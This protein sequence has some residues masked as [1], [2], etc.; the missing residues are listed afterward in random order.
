MRESPTVTSDSGHPVM[1]TRCDRCQTWTVIHKLTPRRIVVA[2]RTVA[3]DRR[4][5][6]PTGWRVG[7]SK[8]TPISYDQTQS[9]MVCPRCATQLDTE[10]LAEREEEAKEQVARSLSRYR[11]FQDTVPPVPPSHDTLCRHH[12]PRTSCTICD[13]LPDPKEVWCRDCDAILT[14]TPDGGFTDSLGTMYCE[15]EKRYHRPTR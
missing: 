5:K 14:I 2:K 9:M 10:I 12:L 13:S 1:E 8:P 4:P 15:G 7:D 6:G 11:E 3:L